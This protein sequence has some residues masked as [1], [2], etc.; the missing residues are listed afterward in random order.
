MCGRLLLHRIAVAVRDADP[1]W[2]QIAFQAALLAFVLARGGFTPRPAQMAL[3]LGAALATQRACERWR[4]LP[5][6]GPWSP[7]ITGL[8]LCLLLR[9]NSLWAPAFA[10][11]AGIASKFTLRLGGKHLFNPSDLGLVAALALTGDA[12]AV[13]GQWGSG[14]LLAFGLGGLGLMTV[15]KVGRFDITASFLA[16]HLGLLALRAA[17]LGYEPAVLLHQA[18]DG[19][20]ILFAF[21]MISDPRATPDARP[22]RVLFAA[23]VALV[24][25]L[26][27]FSWF[28]NH[29][30]LWALLFVSPITPILDRIWRHPRFE[31]RDRGETDALPASL[32]E[33]PVSAG[34][35]RP[36]P[37]PRPAA[38]R[39]R[40]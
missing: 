28:W 29:A 1:R 11:A 4:G 18:L 14:A 10:A 9:A 22:G 27:R 16:A 34:G 3:I 40:A 15:G 39:T 5:P 37:A 35:G 13:P 26:L 19:S 32:P 21:F 38:A 30:L 2:V 6:A 20:L 8:S 33:E 7:L 23:L 17:R 31:W 36:W 24:G 25:H 12:W